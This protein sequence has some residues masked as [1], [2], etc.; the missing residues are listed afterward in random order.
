ML[1]QRPKDDTWSIWTADE[2]ANISQCNRNNIQDNFP[3][4][5]SALK[6]F[7]QWSPRSCA[8]AIG[9]IS[10]ETASS[11]LPVREAYYIYSQDPAEAEILFQQNPT[12]A[13]NW[14]NNTSAHAA[15]SGGPQYHGRGFIQL[16]HDYNYKKV[17]DVIGVDLVSNPDLML[18]PDIAAKG[19]AVY[20]QQ[21]NMQA[22]ADIEDWLTIRKDVVGFVA[23]PPGYNRVNQVASDLV[24]LALQKGVIS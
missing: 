8:A 5:F 19:L 18:Q 6:S 21:R 24:K 10:I 14:Y 2:I 23:N 15:Y 11:F 20:W 3:L 16:T 9:T 22:T 13:Y 17:G 4:V 7:N 1:P 12:P